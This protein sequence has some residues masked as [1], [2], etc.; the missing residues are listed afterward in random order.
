M[1]I[2]YVAFYVIT[3]IIISRSRRDIVYGYLHLYLTDD[4]FN[5]LRLMITQWSSYVKLY[6]LSQCQAHGLLWLTEWRF[7]Y[8]FTSF[9]PIVSPA[10]KGKKC[11]ISNVPIISRCKNHAIKCYSHNK[12]HI[13]FLELYNIKLIDF[14]KINE[15]TFEN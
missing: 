5:W 4:T 2:P 6:W 11:P 8:L 14:N 13:F 12:K 15:T 1:F 9:P 10:L 7:T 3:L